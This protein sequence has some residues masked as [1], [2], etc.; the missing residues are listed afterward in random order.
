MSV[1]WPTRATRGVMGHSLMQWSIPLVVGQVKVRT[2]VAQHLSV[3][4]TTSAP[5]G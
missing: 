5:P 3:K 2:E 1:H 4:R